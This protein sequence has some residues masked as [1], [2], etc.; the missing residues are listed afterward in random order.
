MHPPAKEQS[1]YCEK[2]KAKD[3][4]YKKVATEAHKISSKVSGVLF[5][6]NTMSADTSKKD[7]SFAKAK[8]REG[9]SG[10]C[11]NS[12]ERRAPK[13]TEALMDEMKEYVEDVNEMRM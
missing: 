3:R 8:L 2:Q 13:M 10:T 6:L 11:S 9:L 5:V 7:P 4:E 1:A 12:K